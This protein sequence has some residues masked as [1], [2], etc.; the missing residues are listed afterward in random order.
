MAAPPFAIRNA[1][2]VE[3]RRSP[4]AAKIGTLA[5]RSGLFLTHFEHR[6]P[7]PLPDGWLI[8][9]GAGEAASLR[10]S[11][12]KLKEDKFLHFRYDQPLGSFH[13]SHQGKW[14]SHEL[15][16]GLVG[17]VD[18]R[19]ATPFTI[20]LSARLS[21]VLPVALWYFFDEIELRRCPKHH[22]QGALFG[23]RCERCEWINERG[24]RLPEE[25]DQRFREE[26]LYFLHSELAAV[27]RSR[28]Y[29]HP[30]SHRYS[31]VDLCSD[32]LQYARRH[33]AR[34]SDPLSERFI[35]LFHGPETGCW[36]DLETL[37]ERVLSLSAW[38][39]EGAESPPPLLASRERWIAQ[40]VASR[41]V[42]VAA[43]CADEDVV[44]GLEALIERL[45]THE[46]DA[47]PSVAS[48]YD[49]LQ[50]EW[51]LPSTRE[52]L[53]VGYPLPGGWGSDP[54]WLAEGVRSVCPHLEDVLGPDGLEEQLEGF[55]HWD[56]D[57]PMRQ[58]LAC[59]FA[60]YLTETA[61]G[62]LADIA[63]YESSIAHPGAP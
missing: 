5:A 11:G 51:V 58:P 40:D 47:L 56:L 57:R 17:F 13:P 32:G 45:A 26:G 53:A 27:N 37:E 8:G 30:V 54:A 23:Q 35:E 16:H 62:P 4:A 3:L 31:T 63:R 41:I 61:P 29:R 36:P 38:L 1:P 18:P 20:H 39:A 7:L 50:S 33:F 21:E 9:E 46:L 19:R 6:R 28:R 34:I 22:A 24:P 12:G 49:Q 2:E 10:W 42:T 44:A 52:L 60:D 55:L 14:G 25:E 59:R 48:D 43:G 15:C